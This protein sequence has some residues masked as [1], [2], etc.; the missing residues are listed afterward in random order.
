[1]TLSHEINIAV[2]PGKGRRVKLE[3]NEVESMELAN[4]AGIVSVEWCLC[5][6][7]F[8]RW[9]RDGVAVTGTVKANI[10]QECVVTLEPIQTK[11]DEQIDR[12]FLPDGSKLL[13]PRLSSDGEMIVDF[14]GKD[15]PEMFLGE[16][17]DAWEIAMEHFI[18]GIDLF[19]RKPGA[20]FVISS[21]TE[22]DSE[23]DQSEEKSPFAALK[24]LIEPK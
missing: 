8:R 21:D 1:M 7:E 11:I 20:E 14:E 12:T 22:K 23:I 15:E 4:E 19:A 13:R 2:L 18:L 24:G 10:T 9:R 6:L 17:L 3:P 5:E 16:T